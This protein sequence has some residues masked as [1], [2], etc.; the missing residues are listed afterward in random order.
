MVAVSL[1]KKGRLAVEAIA[2][3]D[4]AVIQGFVLIV[5]IAILII[6]AFVDGLCRIIDPSIKIKEQEHG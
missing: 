1:K 6:M 4:Y 5:G 2:R 3:R